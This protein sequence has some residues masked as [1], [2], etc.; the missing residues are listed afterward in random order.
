MDDLED[1]A[2]SLLEAAGQT[3]AVEPIGVTRPKPRAIWPILAGAAAVMVLVIG[4]AAALAWDDQS[5]PPATPP[6]ELRV[7]QT[8][9]MTP[10][11]ARSTLEALGLAVEIR[12]DQD[13]QGAEMECGLP[14]GRVRDSWPAPTTAVLPGDTVTLTILGARQTGGSAYCVGPHRFE[15]DVLSLL[16]FAR[17]GQDGPQF[18]SSVQLWVDGE[19]QKT[20]TALEAGDPAQWGD[21]SPLSR[22][23]AALDLMS[24]EDGKLVSPSVWS[25]LDQGDQ[26]GCG[27]NDPPAALG[28]RKSTVVTI[29]HQS[30]GPVA[31]CH[32]VRVYR[33][34]AGQVDAVSAADDPWPAEEVPPVQTGVPAEPTKEQQAVAE[35]F[36]D[37]AGGGPAPRFADQVQL[38][39]GNAPVATIDSPDAMDRASWSLTCSGYAERSC[40][41][42]A[43][44]FV[45]K[46]GTAI[47][48][49]TPRERSECH[50]VS[51][52]LPADLTTAQSLSNSVSFGDAEPAQ[53]MD[54]WE[55]Q[56]WLD[57]SG[58]IRAVNLILGSP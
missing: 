48:G 56:L 1:R 12:G 37:F 18:A 19:L 49:T 53:C 35:A 54:N 5:A 24:R 33:N 57:E 23:L 16:D 29:E 14:F 10:D 6:S 17:F 27:S 46:R 47:H 20:L 30:E 21:P 41:I 36:L 50:T 15:E 9:W 11:Q 45:V 31:Q 25:M 55:V 34:Q 32:W 22:M 8:L 51:A 4:L 28:G 43:L 7:P 52:D 58:A 40:P 42:D 38:F 2:R 26:F 13:R 3:I 39:L 44:S